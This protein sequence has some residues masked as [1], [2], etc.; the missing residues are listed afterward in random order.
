MRD[1]NIA[2]L[3]SDDLPLFN[4]ITGD[5]FPNIDVP[6]IDYQILVKAIQ[7]EMQK[8]DLQVNSLLTI[9]FSRLLAVFLSKSISLIFPF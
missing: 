1:M 8:D 6:P 2:K 4:G 5:L 9:Y 7:K 3:T